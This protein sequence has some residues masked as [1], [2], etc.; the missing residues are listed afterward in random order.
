MYV[1]IYIHIYIYTYIYTYI[2]IYI[3]IC[4]CVCVCVCV[5]VCVYLCGA[6][7]C[8]VAAS[9]SS[10]RSPRPSLPRALPVRCEG[11]VEVEGCGC[12]DGEVGL[13]VEG[14]QPGALY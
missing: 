10:A 12:M 3:Y 7:E 2:Y 14:R 9:H 8:T 4:V 13:N 5:F 6:G 1:Y 11:G